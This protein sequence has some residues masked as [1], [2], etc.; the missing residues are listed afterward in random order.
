M[1]NERL[2]LQEDIHHMYDHLHPEDEIC[3]KENIVYQKP[4]TLLDTPF[5]YC[6]GCGHSTVHK[7][8]A[9]V[10]DEMG[11]QEQTIGVAPV[12]C[13]VFAYNYINIDWQ[14]AAHGRASAV[15]TG[16]KRVL[17]D[18]FVFSYQGDGDLAAIG[19][20][21]TIHT[22]NRGEN[23]TIIFINNGI[24]GMTGGQ[25]APTTLEGMKSTT[26]PN[27]RDVHW[28]GYPLKISELLA[29][30]PGTYYVTRQAVFSP[31]HVRKAK[32]AIR[33]AFEYQKL[34]KGT[35]L[36]EIV[37]NCPSNWKMTPTESNMWLQDNMIKY[38]Q[39]GDIK[40]PKKEE[41]K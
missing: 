9:E 25:M 30:L 39:L 31:N 23:I 37:S 27:G 41:A 38:F 34:N 7:L 19:T 14:E 2:L 20:G 40:L 11:I 8:I 15:A 32:K 4:S 21:E 26:S 17:P 12:G 16:I 22:C 13:A 29:Q 28:A 35:C 3:V 1:G 24:Y 6:P 18:K 36:V 33:N 5:H 10:I